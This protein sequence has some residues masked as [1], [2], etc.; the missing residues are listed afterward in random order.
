M[1]IADNYVPVKELG[2][3]TTTVFSGNWAVLNSSFIRVYLENVT[4]G[5]QVLQTLGSDY[6]LSFD[7]SGFEVTFLLAPPSTEYVVISR[8]IAKTQTVP[9]KTSKG[10][11][12]AITEGSFDKV[13]AMIQDIGEGTSRAILLPIGSTASTALPAPT[14]LNL[15]GWNATADAIVNY[16]LTDF[17]S[18][19]EIVTT[20]L[21]N[22]DILTW[23][24]TA[25]E[26]QNIAGPT[27]FGYTLIQNANAAD[28]RTDLDVYSTTEVD[29]LVSAINTQTVVSSATVT[30]TSE[31][32]LVVVTAQA[33]ALDIANPTGTMT[34]G[35]ALIIRIKDNGT[36]RAITYGANYRALGVTLP[37]TTVLSKTLYLAMVWNDTDTKFDVTGVAQEA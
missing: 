24:A 22:G 28:A 32:D 16:T 20:S 25:G 30:P 5:V 18:T 6:T 9:Y 17:P 19:A 26:W 34:Q 10:F 23:N 4:T 31:N 14:A 8:D 37:T 13:T 3:G 27:T 2:N 1:S 12:G 33:E 29:N 36:A 11:Q 7:D 21:A 35:Q 15:F